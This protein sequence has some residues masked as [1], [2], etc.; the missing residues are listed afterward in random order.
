MKL[1]KKYWKLIIG[2]LAGIFGAIFI[3]SKKSTTKKLQ[4][5]KQKIDSNNKSIQK[6][7]GKL[8]YV[9][10]EKAEIKKLIQI[11][12]QYKKLTASLNT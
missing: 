6:I 5:N 2:I 9:T 12:N 1:I 11:T 10:D 8:K 3:F 7:D 4:K